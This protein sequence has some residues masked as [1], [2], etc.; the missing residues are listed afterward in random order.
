M[1]I[2]AVM[3]YVGGICLAERKIGI[4]YAIRLGDLTPVEEMR[5]LGAD[6]VDFKGSVP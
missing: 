1:L 2:G 4:R 6:V 5:A 3:G